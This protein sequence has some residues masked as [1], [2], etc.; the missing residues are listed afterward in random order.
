M[1]RTWTNAIISINVSTKTFY[2]CNFNSPKCVA[3]N[4]NILI[5]IICL[6]R[7][8]VA[9]I[10]SWLLFVRGQ[11]N[12]CSIA[13]TDMDSSLKLTLLRFGSRAIFRVFWATDSTGVVQDSIFLHFRSCRNDL[14]PENIEIFN[15]GNE[16][17]SNI[18]FNRRLNFSK[19]IY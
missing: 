19:I 17:N 12:L 1:C 5:L 3:K 11:S 6:Q 8:I 2:Y 9:T 16:P 13:Q 7:S 14:C 18:H 4:S 10:P 15:W